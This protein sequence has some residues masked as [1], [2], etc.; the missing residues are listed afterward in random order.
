MLRLAQEL[1]CHAEDLAD[2]LTIDGF[3]GRGISVVI[4]N[5]VKTE[6]L[7][8]LE[9]EPRATVAFSRCRDSFIIVGNTALIE[10]EKFQNWKDT[11]KTPDGIQV[12]NP[13]PSFIWYIEQLVKRNLVIEQEGKAHAKQSLQ[14]SPELA[15]K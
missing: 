7:R 8:F 4:L 1:G 13:K 3:Q 12:D 5:L 9:Q 14:K 11:K 6:S 2:T 15:E 10:K